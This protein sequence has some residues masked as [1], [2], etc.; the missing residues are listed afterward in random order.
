[1]SNCRLQPNQIPAH[2]FR[3]YDIRGVVTE[4]LTADIVHDIGVALG[5][6][7]I[8]Q[9]DDR[10]VVGRD[11]RLSGPG[12]L[13]A[14]ID[15]LRST[16]CDVTSIGMV[17]TPVLYF[18]VK[19][20]GFA[21]GVMLTGSHNPVN[22]NGLKMIVGGKTLTGDQVVGLYQRLQSGDVKTG[23]GSFAEQDLIDDYIQAVVDRTDVK[24]GF[25]IV[26]DSGNGATGHI[27]R[28]L[29]EAL[30]CEVKTL[31]TEV[32]GAFPNHHPDPSKIENLQDIIQT[33]KA[34]EYDVGFAFDGDGD[35]LGL[36]TPKGE[37]IYPDRQLMLFAEDVLKQYPGRTICYDVKSTKNLGPF[38]TKA[39]GVPLMYKTG[40]SLLKNKM[41]EENSPVSGEM[42]GHLFFND[43]WFGFDDGMYSAARVLEVLSNNPGKSL[44]QLFDAIPNSISTPELHVA[45]SDDEKFAFMDTLKANIP[46]GDEAK[47]IDIDGLRVEFTDA[48]GLIRPSNT[49]PCLTLRYEADNQAALIRIQ[50][51]FK[52]WMLS[53]KSGLEIMID[54]A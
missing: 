40:H 49:T 1:M 7:A 30:G 48:W 42:S 46:F 6:E 29:F 14:L 36:L 5:S 44:D 34:G 39:G 4:D 19:H 53:C 33:L 20:L 31:F 21:N 15:G 52:D 28:K 2:I 25:K 26:V 43:K 8:A 47:I 51:Q 3:A 13:Q 32:D 12:H 41:L 24:P 17:A 18:A 9:G 35:R 23:Q 27:V 16:G 22:Y 38:I 50:E 37:M 45:I 10:V 54:Q 11:G